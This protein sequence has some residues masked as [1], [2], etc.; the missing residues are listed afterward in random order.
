MQRVK[1]ALCGA[2][3]VVGKEVLYCLSKLKFPVDV[4][5]I[6]LF[7][8][9]RSAG[10]K[11]ETPFGEM[12]FELFELKKV[13]DFDIV[14]LSVGGGFSRQYARDLAEQNGLVIDKSS[15][16]RYHKDVPLIIPEI[17]GNEVKGKGLVSSPNCTTS[18]L[19]MPLYPIYKAF[20]IKKVIVSTYQ[21]ASGAGKA[22]MDELE[23]QTRNWAT[24]NPIENDAF[25]YQ[26]PF[27]IIPHIDVFQ[28]NLYTKE[29]M[30]MVWEMRKIFDVS[31]LKI[32]CTSVRIPTIRAHAESVTIETEKPVTRVG[33]LEVLAKAKGVE[34]VDDSENNQYPM[35]L[36]ATGKF[37]I[38]V[39]RIRENEV[40]G[41]RG[42][43]FFVCGDQLLRGAALN[44]VLIA[45]R[46]LDF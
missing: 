22:G 38:E 28:E 16:F 46:A 15:Y 29:E 41:N 9:S 2:S 31:D 4:S 26:L 24:G 8:S 5:S 39:G 17:N 32:S 13:K 30:K 6:S 43:D 20:G 14:F 3:G 25:V 45:K 10:Q 1:I 23:V 36:S 42:L 11:T 37:D 34:I 44:A 33:A 18:I 19:A 35:P 7:T 21:S 40:F 12:M 27:N